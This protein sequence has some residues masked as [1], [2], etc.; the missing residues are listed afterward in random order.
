[1]SSRA[2]PFF[3]ESSSLGVSSAVLQT[4]LSL[5]GNDTDF[6]SS[7]RFAA[8][9]SLND[10][11]DNYRNNSEHLSLPLRRRGYSSVIIWQQLRLWSS[12]WQD[13]L[14]ITQKTQRV[15]TKQICADHKGD[16]CCVVFGDG[17]IIADDCGQPPPPLPKT[18]LKHHLKDI[19]LLATRLCSMHNILVLRTGM[20]VEICE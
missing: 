6:L 11:L 17:V 16:S 12:W 2:E 14:F 20:C 13:P 19:A 8:K 5:P 10:S 15:I 1:M 4:K 18:L 9:M 3:I 7:S